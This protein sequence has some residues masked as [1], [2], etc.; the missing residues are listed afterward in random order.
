[1]PELVNALLDMEAVFVV[2]PD[3]KLIRNVNFLT[4]LNFRVHVET[5]ALGELENSLLDAADFYVHNPILTTPV[6]PFH[7]LLH[8]ICIGRG[9]NMWA[10]EAENVKTNFY[11]S[12]DGE[13]SLSKRWNAD[14]L[15]YATLDDPWERIVNSELFQKL[16]DFR[17]EL[18][19]NKSPCVFCA[20]LDLCGG[21]LRA[22]D[23]SWPC[24]LWQQVF[25]VLR[26]EAK[27]G[28]ELLQRIEQMSDQ[29][30]EAQ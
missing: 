30:S 24:E 14:G 13:V 26:D 16:S 9:H 11:V 28:K 20:Y 8:T 18:F 25:C 23:A 4:S 2:R 27:K 12:H 5:S 22:I 1:M 15:N 17:N 21:F 6:E 7:T 29:K 10:I 19:R 3:A